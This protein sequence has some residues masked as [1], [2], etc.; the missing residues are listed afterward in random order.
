MPRHISPD[1]PHGIRVEGL[2]LHDDKIL[3]VHRI[4]KGKEYYVLPGG[5]WEDDE[6]PEEGVKREV[7]EET[8]V[9]VTVEEKIFE[10]NS[11]D[12]AKKLTYLCRY[13][14]GIPSI[15]EGPE[16][17]KMARDSENFYEPLWLDIE[18]IPSIT[19]YSEEFQNWLIT[20]YLPQHKS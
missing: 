3:L 12:R 1:F 16:K 5:G 15:G 11:P 4:K 18:K 14:S 13:V 6:T 20:T 9:T 10:L 2:V 7:L 17:E 19:L 8:S